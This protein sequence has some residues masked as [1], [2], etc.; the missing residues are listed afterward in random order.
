MKALGLASFAACLLIAFAAQGGDDA[1]LK[2]EKAALQGLWKIVSVETPNG[3]KDDFDGAT[4]DF[5]KD[6]KNLTFTKGNETKKGTYK[7]NPAGKPKEI[8]ISPSDDNQKTMEGIYVIEKN[9]L[10]ICLCPEGSGDGRPTE[11]V[12]K[13]GKKHVLMTAERAK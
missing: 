11:F 5:N 6:G 4:L 2:K 10:K 3:K 12:V 7:L 8:D 9:T 13:D 1:A